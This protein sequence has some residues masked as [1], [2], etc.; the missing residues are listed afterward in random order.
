MRP[1]ELRLRNF[2]SYFGPETVF[3][4]RDRSL[5]GIVGPIGS[6]KSSILDAIS[7][8]LY[9]KTPTV[10]AATKGLIHQRAADA[11]VALRFEVEGEIWEAVRMLRVKGQS[12]HALYRLDA[13][14]PSDAPGV[15]PI[16]RITMEADVNAKVIELLGLEFDAFGR[17]VLLAQGRF[18][19]FLRARPV[20]R[21]KVLKGVF[22]HDRID[23]MR[24]AAKAH[25][26]AVAIE[27]EKMGVR[28]EQ[29]DRVALRLAERTTQ[30]KALNSRLGE[31]EKARPKLE[32]LEVQVTAAEETRATV[33]KR[34]ADIRGLAGRLPE[35]ATTAQLFA[36]ASGVASRRAS[37]AAGLEAAQSAVA[38]ADAA[39]AA[40][41]AE[42]IVQT[43][44]E[45]SQRLAL[46]NPLERAVGQASQR[47]DAVAKR[48]TTLV[49]SVA[50][51]KA[52]LDTAT[53]AEAAA[54]EQLTVRKE[55][56]E[57][58]ES[59]LQQLR[60]ADM[61]MTLRADLHDGETCPVCAQA[62]AVVPAVAP[63]ADV[64][65]AV[66]ALDDARAARERADATRLEAVAEVQGARE[67]LAGLEAEMERLGTEQ[68][69]AQQAAD[70][71]TQEYTDAV[72]GLTEL[73]G[74]GDP[75]EVVA[76]LKRDVESKRTKAADARKALERVRMDHDA[77]I[78]DQQELEK[79][80]T[81]LRVDVTDLA[82]RLGVELI[83]D[84]DSA[85]GLEQALSELRAAWG[86]VIESLEATKATATQAAAEAAVARDVLLASLSVAGDFA[87]VA[88]TTR[89]EADLVAKLI[90]EGQSELDQSSDLL[91]RRDGMAAERDR[92]EQI[93]TDLTDSRFVRY[94]LDDE[95]TR[96]AALGSE[97]FERLSSGRYRFSEDGKFEILDL[98]AA[99][100]VRK[101]DSLS[102]GETFLASLALVLALAEMVARTGG[103][104]DAFFL[105]EGFG[106]LD[107]EHLDLAME[108][109][110]ALVADGGSRL[111]VVVSHVPELRARLEDLIVLDRDPVTG[112][113]R[114]VSA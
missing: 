19:E 51:A 88:A 69:A 50:Q 92:Y 77:V 87:G 72:S 89:A 1:L 16:E 52:R 4:F 24:D 82:A 63:S 59:E 41:E 6:G 62:V 66:G 100:A 74:E 73:L 103:R 91:V 39:L 80:L 29:L 7:F 98:T 28:V 113:T 76:R 12:Q 13:D 60:H 86:S 99:E 58:A 47:V 35:P 49:A 54:S 30:A 26:A 45:A 61:A 65:R 85:G 5:V 106:S 11:A 44:D 2:R 56:L 34:L 38:D 14:E 31:L 90:E 17:S 23:A 97:H 67:A 79:R 70:V 81:A 71:A 57:A 101:A 64:S 20:E 36:D 37:L 55:T 40:A 78:R 104:L 114:V 32:K 33:E 112:D 53:G 94:L 108:G 111:V 15:E 84:G 93:S 3:S 102:G 109:I 83:A 27:L 96:L 42:G 95:R 43:I 105:D 25:A 75:A 46:I 107:P 68:S 110:E 10:A 48:L 8:A 22:G 18:A 9:G 21:D